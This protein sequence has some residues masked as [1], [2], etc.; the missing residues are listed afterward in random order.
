MLSFL[1]FQRVN[2][3]KSQNFSPETVASMVSR[4]PYILNFSVKRLDNRMGFYQKRLKLSA[5]NVS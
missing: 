2:F 1:V 5:S 4:A 3:L